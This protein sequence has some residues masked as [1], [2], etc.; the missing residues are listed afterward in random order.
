MT[1]AISRPSEEQKNN[2][3]VN[4]DINFLQQPRQSNSG[5][6]WNKTQG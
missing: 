1:S 4:R 2:F 6:G 3:I 5:K